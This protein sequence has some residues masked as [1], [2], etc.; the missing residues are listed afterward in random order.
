MS[1][2]KNLYNMTSETHT[3]TGQLGNKIQLFI[4][5]FVNLKTNWS[6][7]ENEIEKRE[8]INSIHN[9]LGDINNLISNLKMLLTSIEEIQ[10]KNDDSKVNI[11]ELT[12]ARNKLLEQSKEKARK[13]DSLINSLQSLDRDI[14]TY[15]TLKEDS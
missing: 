4:E 10:N 8:K 2:S 5:E 14:Q 12:E 13:I 3:L 7:F 11:D 1:E 15:F 9:S 6:N